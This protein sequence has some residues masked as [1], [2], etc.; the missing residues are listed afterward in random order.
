MKKIMSI[1]VILVFVFSITG[2]GNNKLDTEDNLG[3]GEKMVSGNVVFDTNMGNFEVELYAEKAPITVKNFLGYVN[4]GYYDGLIFHRVIKGFM[5][6]GGGFD[7]DMNQKSTKDPIKNEADNGLKNEKY[8]LAMARTNVVDSATSQFFVNVA[9]NTFLDNS[10]R[11]FGYAVFGRVVLGQEIIDKI[12]STKTGTKN[13][14]GD[15]PVSEVMIN[16]AYVKE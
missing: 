8:T 9:E 11:D 16:K 13:G 4:E 14:M 15:V 5:V 2:C 6:Q 12:E 10:D 3:G 7:A 1:M